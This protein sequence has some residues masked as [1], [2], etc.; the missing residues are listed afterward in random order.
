MRYILIGTGSPAINLDRAGTSHLAVVGDDLLLFD[1]GPG[2]THRLHRAD[3]AL[4]RIGYLFLTHH[5]YDHI[6]DYG[7]FALARWDSARQPSPL[8]V[9]GPPGT[10]RI[11]RALFGADGVYHGDL[12]ARTRHPLSQSIFAMRGGVLPRPALDVRAHDVPQGLVHR[13]AGWR[14]LAGP[15]RHVQPFLD[16]YSY[17]LETQERT[18]VYSG[19]TGLCP[20]LAEFARGADTLVHMCCFPDEVVRSADIAASVA[21]PSAAGRVAAAAGIRKLVLTHPQST[22][23]DTPNGTAAAVAQA[24]RFFDGDVVFGHDL[25][26]I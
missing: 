11:T 4:T 8:D 2:I 12:T 19:D 18:V 17:R 22:E 26:E 15:A 14:V 3:I 25:L 5:H 7:H 23:M 21:G 20:E 13:T 6:A 10:E 24:R 9:F 16:C 1:C